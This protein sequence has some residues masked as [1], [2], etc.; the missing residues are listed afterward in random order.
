MNDID[1][2]REF[3]WPRSL[4]G[5]VWDPETY[6]AILYLLLSLPLGVFYFVFLITGFALGL[7]LAIVWIGLPILL[8]MML[9]V[10][11][12]TGF[13]RLLAIHLLGKDVTP[14]REVLPQESAWEWLKGVLTTPATWKG[15]LFLLLKMPFGIFSF[16]VTVTLLAISVA[17]LLSPVIILTGGTVDLGF[18]VADTLPEGVMCSFLGALLHLIHLHLLRGLAW[19]WAVLSG[20]LLGKSL[21]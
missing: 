9:S 11:G 17:L 13:E 5:V 1:R 18:W 16:V 21:S 3:E 15:L 7:G 4:V 14:L 2:R 6:Q 8:L 10:Y 20:A 12:L 19:I